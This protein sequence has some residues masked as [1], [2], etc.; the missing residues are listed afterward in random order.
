M[1]TYFRKPRSV[2]II[3]FS[4]LL[5]SNFLIQ[6]NF[7]QLATGEKGFGYAKSSFHR[8]IKGFMI[9]GGDFTNGDGT[10]G[11]SIYGAKFA[12]EGFPFKHEGPGY[13]R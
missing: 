5:I 4:V 9:Q 12:D 6:E 13:L 1:E 7:R 10:G 2:H 11:K 8:I 3:H